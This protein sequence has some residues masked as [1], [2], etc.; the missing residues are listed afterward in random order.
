MEN[1]S[2][3]SY[4][5]RAL[6]AALAIVVAAAVAASVAIRMSHRADSGTS[7]L[8]F[9]KGDPDDKRPGDSKKALVGPNDARF[10][11]YNAGVEAYLLRAYQ[12]R[13]CPERR[14]WRR[15]AGGRR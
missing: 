13:K 11:D 2:S 6:I 3:S 12:K 8:A 15:R 14:R 1:S 4:V 7:P 5:S 10:A 9:A